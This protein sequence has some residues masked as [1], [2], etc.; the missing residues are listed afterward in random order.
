MKS[1]YPSNFKTSNP[2]SQYT[3]NKQ[4]NSAEVKSLNNYVQSAYNVPNNNY[5]CNWGYGVEQDMFPTLLEL[6]A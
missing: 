3:D 1:N 4:V 6:R 2:Y 5:V